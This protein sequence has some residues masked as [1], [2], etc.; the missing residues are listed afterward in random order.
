MTGPAIVWENVS[1]RFRGSSS[2]ALVGLNLAV[3]TG[4]VLCLIGA[5]GS[6]KT[7]ALKM[8]N[9]MEEPTEGRVL[10][11]GT[12]VSG[13]DPIPLRR[14]FGYVVQSGG[15]FPHMSV[16]ANAGLPGKLE[17]WAAHTIKE[18]V[19][20]VLQLV[21]LPLEE[22]G[23]RPPSA[24]SGG[25]QQRVGVARA[26]FLDP[27]YLLMDEPFG[28]LDPITRIQLQD[29]FLRLVHE[30]RKTV[31]LVTHD[32]EEACRLGNRVAVMNQ[33][34]LLQEGAPADLIERPADP[35]VEAMLS[36][37]LRMTSKT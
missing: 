31:V 23:K 11:E 12:D 18:R 8:I 7:T 3:N 6:G 15:L 32:M 4:E 13:L 1:K 26:L 9:R 16:E 29:E 22:F 17:G 27:D 24:L 5:S 2:A 36:G 30:Q 25:Q 37:Y 28:A 20:E 19:A 21:G 35:F 10:L 34:K 33:G 14:R